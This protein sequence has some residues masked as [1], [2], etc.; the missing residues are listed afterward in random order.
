LVVALR[1][2]SYWRVTA[3]F[4]LRTLRRWSVPSV[5]L[6]IFTCRISLVIALGALRVPLVVP[7][8]TLS[9]WR[10]A[11]VLPLRTLRRW[12][13]PPVSLR[14]LGSC[15]ISLVIALG[16]LRALLLCTGA[17]VPRLALRLL[18]RLRRQSV[19]PSWLPRVFVRR[20][21]CDGRCGEC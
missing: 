19:L 14:I 21:L 10:V 9:C 17:W 16:T 20:G 8:G 4:P 11:A 15:R 12:W 18:A 5:S 13:V 1:T 7:L 3:F 2:L 6:R